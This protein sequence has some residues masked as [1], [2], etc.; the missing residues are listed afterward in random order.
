MGSDAQAFRSL[1]AL[2]PGLSEA[3]LRL[4]LY[5]ASIQDPATHTAKASSRQI[6]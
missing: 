5:L 4:A 1:A 6:A 3:E 2:A